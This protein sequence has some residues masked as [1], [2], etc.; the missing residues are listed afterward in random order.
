MHEF[1][2][3]ENLVRALE[4][5]LAEAG[6]DRVAAVRFRRGSA[7]SDEA[8]H[9]AFAMLSAGTPLEGAEL[10]VETGHFTAGRVTHTPEEIRHR[11]SG[12]IREG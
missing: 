3:V 5:Q 8:L 2:V 12:A 4:R 10:E 7:F 6:V 11:F 9:Q 1:G